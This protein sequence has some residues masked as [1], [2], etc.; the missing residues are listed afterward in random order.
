MSSEP[1]KPTDLEQ[2]Q[3]K[4]FSWLLA[5]NTSIQAQVVGNTQADVEERL[6]IYSNAYRFRLTDALSDSYPSI[7]T[8]MGDEAFYA[9]SNAYIDTHPSQHFSLRYFGHQLGSFLEQYDPHNLVLAEM[10][11]FEW[12]L[13]NSFDS[14]DIAPITLQDLQDIPPENWGSL[15]FW[16]HPSVARLDLNWNTPQLWAA[17][18]EEAAPVT[19]EQHKY[20][21]PWVLW[22][23]DLLTYYRSLDVDEAWALDRALEGELF[24]KLCEGVCEWVDE[25]HAPARVAAFI[26][27]WIQDDMIIAVKT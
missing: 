26:A 14:E 24:A 11:K 13:R 7:H 3:D 17:I 1:K 15:N 6:T 12:T 23:H 5:E 9:M 2:L 27:R 25:E 10:A 21:L 8:L 22:R 18:D 20:P 4:L 19:P 16:F